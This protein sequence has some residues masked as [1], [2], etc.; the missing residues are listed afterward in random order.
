MKNILCFFIFF[1]FTYKCLKVKT[2]NSLKMRNTLGIS[3]EP[4]TE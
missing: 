3:D 1:T 2:R 4:F